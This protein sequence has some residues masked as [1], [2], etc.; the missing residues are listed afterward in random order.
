MTLQTKFYI[1]IAFVIGFLL[2]QTS[3]ISRIKKQVAELRAK[4][5]ADSQIISIFKHLTEEEYK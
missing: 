4:Q 2:A 5:I 1:G 3:D